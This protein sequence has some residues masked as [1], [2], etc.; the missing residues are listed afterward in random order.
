[1]GQSQVSKM[2]T[3][4][5]TSVA[6]HQAVKAVIFHGAHN[7]SCLG[8]LMHIAQT[9]CRAQ[10]LYSKRA[11]DSSPRSQWAR[12]FRQCLQGLD[13]EHSCPPPKSSKVVLPSCPCSPPASGYLQVPLK[14]PTVQQRLHLVCRLNFVLHLDP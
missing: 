11:P 6:R 3:A 5:V 14:A 8:I 12:I 10:A 4:S 13:V 2:E 1:M 9:S 7:L